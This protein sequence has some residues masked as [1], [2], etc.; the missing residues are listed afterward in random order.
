MWSLFER[1]FLDL[2]NDAERSPGDGCSRLL[3]SCPVALLAAQKVYLREVF[4]DSLGY[5][6]AKMIRW[7][8][9]LL[10]SGHGWTPESMSCK[11]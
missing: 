10:T 7:V 3:C 11:C 5:A 1:K 9:G 6:G 2:W 8:T 4:L